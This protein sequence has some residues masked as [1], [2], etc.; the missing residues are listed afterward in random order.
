MAGRHNSLRDWAARTY[1]EAFGLSAATVQ[2]VPQWDRWHPCTCADPASPACVCT[3]DAERGELGVWERAVLDVATSD[4]RTGRAVYFDVTVVCA[5][6]DDAART[7]ARARADGR[8]AGDAV[9]DK[10]RRYESA[11][12]AL[13]PL[14]FESGGRPADGTAAFVRDCGAALASYGPEVGQLTA[15]LW[16]ECSTLLQLGNAELLLSAAGR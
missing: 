12:P 2:R 1:A 3:H 5:H 11:G 6:S 4:P 16:Q 14:A 10:R 15:R 13:R 8:A 9:A 7:R